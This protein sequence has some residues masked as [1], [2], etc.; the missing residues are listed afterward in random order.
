MWKNYEENG[1][2]AVK[3]LDFTKW[4]HDLYRPGGRFPY[5]PEEI[6]IIRKLGKLADDEKQMESRFDGE[7][8]A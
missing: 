7:D 2:E 8:F 6:E 1:Y 4:Q 3:H 5:D